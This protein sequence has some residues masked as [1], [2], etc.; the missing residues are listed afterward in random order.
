MWKMTKLINVCEFQS[1]LWK[2]KKGPFAK[3]KVIRNTNFRPNG[4]LSYENIP[5]LDVES[6]ELGKR[7]LQHGDIILEKSGGGAKTPVGRVC[8]FEK[9]K[10]VLF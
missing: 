8:L 6:K 3:A 4:N 10:F 2:G 7:E 5:L 1:G 9:Q